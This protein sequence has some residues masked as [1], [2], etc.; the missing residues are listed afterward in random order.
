MELK[1]LY[2]RDPGPGTYSENA[3]TI[4]SSLASQMKNL[5]GLNG[6]IFEKD[7]TSKQKRFVQDTDMLTTDPRINVA[8]GQYNPMPVE[9]HVGAPKLE[10]KGDFSLPFNEKN[11][12]NYVKPITVNIYFKQTNPGVGQYNPS[13]VKGNVNGNAS[14]F[15]SKQERSM[16]PKKKAE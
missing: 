8:P 4:E 3:S 12:L 16:M 13:P 9:K 7:F 5:I 6:Q 1:E 10:Y 11:P 14:V 15:N 2:N